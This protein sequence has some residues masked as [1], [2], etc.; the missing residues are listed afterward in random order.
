MLPSTGYFKTINCPFY[1]SGSCDRPYCHFKHARRDA[2]S[3]A[4][5]AGVVED[6]ATGQ[7]Q[8]SK[9]ADV[10]SNPD[11]L[12]QLVSEAVKKVLADQKVT[13][14]EQVSQNIVSQVVEGLKP[15]LASNSIAS[16]HNVLP[17]IV[18]RNIALPATITKPNACVYNPT[19]IAELK[20][21]HIPVVSYMLTRE[22]RVAVKRKPSPEG[23]KPWLSIV[24]EFENSQPEVTYKPT[25]IVNQIDQNA[26]NNYMS[27][28][29]S[30]ASSN[31]FE[32]GSNNLFKP[33]EEYHPKSKKRR[34]EYVPKKVKAPLKTVQQL[35]DSTLDGYKSDTF[36]IMDEVFAAN[37]ASNSLEQELSND[38]QEY[39][40]DIEPKFSD[41]ESIEDIS[42]NKD[43]TTIKK[44]E[45]IED[46]T[47][48]EKENLQCASTTTVNKQSN[49]KDNTINNNH[50]D[51]T[52]DAESND[53]S[54][55]HETKDADKS[56][57]RKKDSTNKST[58]KKKEKRDSHS[59]S[60]ER[61]RKDRH[62]SERRDKEKSRHKSDSKDRH[63]SSSSK[64]KDRKKSDRD[65]SSHRS[66]E[67]S[68]SRKHRHASSKKDRNDHKSSQRDKHRSSSSSK[69]SKHTSSK[70]DRKYHSESSQKSDDFFKK[71]SKRKESNS[72][73]KSSDR[74]SDGSPSSIYSLI[75][76]E[77]LG[78]SDSDHDIQ[79]ECLKIFQEYQPCDQSKL[80][81]LKK[82]RQEA[83]DT[84]EIGKKRIAH[85]SAATNVTRNVGSSQP[86]KKVINPQLRMYE[87]WR[88]MKT[89]AAEMAAEKAAANA[90]THPS[91][92]TSAS[93]VHVPSTAR[94]E[95]TEIT[96][97][98]SNNDVQSN[99][100]G[101]VRIA[102]VPYAKSLALE[103]KKVTETVVKTADNKIENK[104]VAQTTKRA[105]VAHI[106]QTMP[107][108][109]RS[110]PLQGATQKFPINV[111][112]YYLNLMHDVCV[113]IYTNGDDASQRAVKEE[114]ACHE[115]CKA[116]AVYKNSCMLAIHKLK[117]EVDQNKNPD[118]KSSG[119]NYGMMSHE[120]VLAGKSKG[121]WSVIKN[122]RNLV[123][124]KGSAFYNILKKWILSE[125][126]LRDNGFPRKHPDG[127]K[128]R[129]KIYI[130]NA[131]NEGVLSKVPN[132]RI[133]SRCGQTYMVNKHG[134]A[135]L[136]Q[137]CIFHWGR[138]FTFRGESKYSC[139]QQFGS[140]SGCCDAKTHVWDY[141]DYEN[142]R[143]YVTTLSKSIPT[144]EQ[145]IYALDCEMC[146]TTQGLELTRV[147]VIDEDCKVI[148]ET[149][150]KPQNS[151]IDYNTRFS[152]ITEED[153]KDVTTTILDVQATLLTMFSDKTILVGHSLESDFKALKLLHDTVVDTSVMFP[154]KNGYPQKR[155]LKN[156][157][158]E[159]LKKIIQNDINGHDSNEDAV[160]C[161][162]LVKWK[163]KEE[164]KLQ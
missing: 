99:T 48:K 49:N 30:D 133:C 112:Q 108:L 122:K 104:T 87:R 61:D 132:E 137:N 45:Q 60:R 57:E 64:D 107:Q 9:S 119:L 110:E 123:D 27:V 125:T 135:V 79:E 6:Q 145:G 152:G 67:H 139:C 78:L 42:K 5:V 10:A 14:T 91:Q 26:G 80:V 106:P 38:S 111:R 18:G 102:H 35:N 62:S 15:T 113:Q 31:S 20:K 116:L 69:S 98:I 72:E 55:Q 162:E 16:V 161:M 36:D 160:A 97:S 158:S 89:Q 34:E 82:E 37:I 117:K 53:K 134:F 129:A 101:R 130:R 51:K 41:D 4:G 86:Q 25:A 19:P 115:K 88:F 39:S 3:T 63:R 136:Q 12:Q 65:K 95:Y 76:D 58:D 2:G 40:L 84:E 21:R 109:I 163:V 105:R 150:V 11:M 126:Q 32:G 44:T 156:L 7:A 28:L 1:D 114:F 73:D 146:Y 47:E 23:I 141:V 159:Y 83:E 17:N 103:K 144:D 92:V 164:V 154:H 75:D 148:Y 120:A 147:T 90:S 94:K 77:M 142:L 8:E 54:K 118:E 56:S 138:K 131:R 70:S 96:S 29:Q 68:D 24:H 43:D 140:A 157:C 85:P 13:D 153:M 151:I 149:L 52:S 124:I 155:A 66:R 143:G 74:S 33:K 71:S 59:K 22:S 46:K 128:G 121:S 93:A 100:N 127:T 81:S 50:Y